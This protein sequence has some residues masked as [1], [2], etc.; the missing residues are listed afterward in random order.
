MKSSGSACL[1]IGTSYHSRGQ[2]WHDS[3]IRTLAKQLDLAFSVCVDTSVKVWTQF[4]A[5]SI[6]SVF[7]TATMLAPLQQNYGVGG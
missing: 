7:N 3:S 1:A 5:C 2:K 6:K 4:M